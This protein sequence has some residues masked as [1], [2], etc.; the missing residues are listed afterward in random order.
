MNVLRGL[1]LVGAVALYGCGGGDKGAPAAAN[2]GVPA[3]Q[4]PA[5]VTTEYDAGAASPGVAYV[6]T[7]HLQTF[8]VPPNTEAWKCQDFKTPFGNQQVDVIKW[9][10]QMTPGSH[11]LTVFETP[12]AND[13]PLID[14]QNG[15]SNGDLAYAYGSQVPHAV[16]TVPEGVGQVMQAGIGFTLNSHYVNTTATKIHAEVMLK[17]SVAAPGVVTQHAGIW[18]GVLG[19][20]SVPPTH[21]TPVTV[22]SSCTLPQDMKV[23]AIAGHMHEHGTNF[24]AKSGGQMLAQTD[25]VASPPTYFSPPLQLKKGDDIT[26]SCDYTNAT[27]QAL[28]YGPSALTNVMCNTV[29]AFYPTTDV[30]NALLACFH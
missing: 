1:G 13:G 19:S 16:S 14:C 2:Q 28:V 17:I 6:V 11:H 8:D 23:F 30:N 24:V 15:P 27:G 5:S 18:E 12:N 20:I 3:G 22:G 21:G 25:E 29:V 4:T 10:N 26:W 9:E 7:M